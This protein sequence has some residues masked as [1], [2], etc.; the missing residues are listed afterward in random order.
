MSSLSCRLDAY[1]VL[2]RPPAGKLTGVLGGT[3]PGPSP[4]AAP[5]QPLAGS[6]VLRLPA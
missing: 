1:V 4:A 2:T 3:L 5:A 6:Y